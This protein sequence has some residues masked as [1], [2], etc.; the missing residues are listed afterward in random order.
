MEE[1]ETCSSRMREDGSGMLKADVVF[2]D[3]GAA[4]MSAAASLVAKTTQYLVLAAM[5]LNWT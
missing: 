2:P 3:D 1:F 4:L 5:T